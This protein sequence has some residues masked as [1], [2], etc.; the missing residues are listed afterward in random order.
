MKVSY[1]LRY[2][3]LSN[4]HR[5][6]YQDYRDS[7]KEIINYVDKGCKDIYVYTDESWQGRNLYYMLLYY[8]LIYSLPFDVNKFSNNIIKSTSVIFCT[9]IDL[10][11]FNSNQYSINKITGLKQVYAIQQ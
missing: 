1:G 7:I 6:L 9:E 11:Q 10:N 8:D 2:E 4:Q 5:F 3:I